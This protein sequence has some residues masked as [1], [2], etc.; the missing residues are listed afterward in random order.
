M[1][2]KGIQGDGTHRSNAGQCSSVGWVLPCRN[3][4]V[5][6][7]RSLVNISDSVQST[8][9]GPRRATEQ[10]KITVQINVDLVIMMR[11][12]KKLDSKSE[13]RYESRVAVVGVATARVSLSVCVCTRFSNQRGFWSTLTGYIC[14]SLKELCVAVKSLR[15]CRKQVP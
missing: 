4:T 11:G 1:I 14:P 6:R 9:K 5:D 7:R 10:T 13:S 12:S 15:D 8:R 2:G 3:R